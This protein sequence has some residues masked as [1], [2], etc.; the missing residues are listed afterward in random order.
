MQ[1]WTKLY[2]QRNENITKRTATNARTEKMENRK[3]FK[4]GSLEFSYNRNLCQDLK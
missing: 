1:E 2:L 4:A 3:N